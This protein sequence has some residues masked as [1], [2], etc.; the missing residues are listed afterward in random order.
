MKKPGIALFSLLL[1]GTS[2]VQAASIVDLAVTGLITPTACTPQL[3]DGAVIDYGKISQQ[4][5]KVDR[6]TRLPVKPLHVNIACNAP[7]RFALRMHD[8]RDGSAMVN[9]EIYYGLGLDHSGNRI[10]LYSMTFDPLQTVVDS[11]AQAY[12]TESTTGG[13]AWR[14]ANLNPI[15]IGANSYLGFTD[16]AGSTAGPSAIQTLSSTVK[17]ETLINATQ[18]LDLSRETALDGLATLEVVYL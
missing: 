13:L 14:T 16:T 6:S 11:T 5:L 9:S 7:N 10:G 2:A 17:V 15:S 12:G 4:D 18:N 8:N 3:S 1:G